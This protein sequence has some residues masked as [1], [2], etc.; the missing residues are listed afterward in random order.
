[1]NEHVISPEDIRIFWNQESADQVE[2][3]SALLQALGGSED[4]VNP[5]KS[6]RE[7]AGKVAA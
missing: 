3:L 1:M 4:A 5:T 7:F 2:I 6:E